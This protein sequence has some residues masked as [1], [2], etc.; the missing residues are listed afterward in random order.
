MVYNR[1][2]VAGCFGLAACAPNPIKFT[3]RQLP[4]PPPPELPLI[5]EVELEAL[6]DNA[7]ERL[8]ERELRLREY[9]RLLEAHCE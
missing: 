8:V 4:C 9:V 7:Y 5:M 2:L 6:T 3:A 1:L